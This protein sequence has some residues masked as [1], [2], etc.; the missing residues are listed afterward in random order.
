[1]TRATSFVWM[2]VALLIGATGLA[3]SQGAQS[4][5]KIEGPMDD[6]AQ[7][8]KEK[9]AEFEKTQDPKFVY[10]ALDLMEAAEAKMSAGDLTARRLAVSHRLQFFAELDRNIDTTWDPK[11]VPPKGVPPP[12][13]SSGV[14]YS[15]G[16]VDPVSI[17][18]LQERARYVEALKENKKRN[19]Q[20]FVQSQLRSI[21][22][23]AMRFTERLL[24]DTYT[25]AE[26]AREEFEGLLAS[27]QLSQARKQRLLALLP[28]PG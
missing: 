15:S 17:P 3:A 20:Y 4:K 12:P 19:Q 5:R 25:K 24:A 22:E 28:K 8:V 9:F 1:M 11:D 23:R 10:Q 7:Q 2:Y 14:V 18:D 13:S 6:T 21:D 27:S 26:K 16:E